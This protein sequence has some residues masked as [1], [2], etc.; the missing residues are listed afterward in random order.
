MLGGFIR[1]EPADSKKL[2]ETLEVVDL[3]SRVH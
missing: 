1:K 2:R 3:F